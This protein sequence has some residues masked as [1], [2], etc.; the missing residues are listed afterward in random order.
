MAATT[1]PPVTIRIESGCAV[2]HGVSWDFYER[3]LEEFDE[4]YMPHGYS[5]G[6]FSIRPRTPFIKLRTILMSRLVCVL[7]EVLEIPCRSLG[8]SLLKHDGQSLQVALHKDND[9]YEVSQA[10]RAFSA[11]PMKEFAQG[12]EQA[13]AIDETAWIGSFRQ[14]VRETVQIAE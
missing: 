11:L 1:L 6:I 10:S 4:G 12:I 13:D 14:W 5:T 8:A 9:S 7:T 2:L 3:F